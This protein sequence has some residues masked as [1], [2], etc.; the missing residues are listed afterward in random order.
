MTEQIDKQAKQPSQVACFSED[1]KCLK[2]Y[3][4]A[5]S[6]GHHTIDRLEALKEASSLNASPPGDQWC[7][8]L[9]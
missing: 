3:L 6:Q 7:D 4:R 2:H 9:G 5:Q 1:L 8:V